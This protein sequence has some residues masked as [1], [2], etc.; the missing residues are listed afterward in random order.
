[1]LKRKD[2]EM[3]LIWFDLEI[4]SGKVWREGAEREREREWMTKLCIDNW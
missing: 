2:Y 1:M 4:V 3:K